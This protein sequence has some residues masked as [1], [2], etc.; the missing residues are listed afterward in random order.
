MVPTDLCVLGLNK[1]A[2]AGNPQKQIRY[3]ILT[4]GSNAILEQLKKMHAFD[5]DDFQYIENEKQKAKDK[6]TSNIPV[7]KNEDVIESN[8]VKGNNKNKMGKNEKMD[9]DNDIQI[10]VPKGKNSNTNNNMNNNTGN[11]N[12]NIS[13]TGNSSNT[14]GK[15]GNSNSQKS[16]F[17]ILTEKIIEMENMLKDPSNVNQKAMLTKDYRKLL[18][19]RGKLV[20]KD[21]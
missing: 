4:G 2:I 8:N 15:K 20:P 6:L 12:S 9:L 17:D 3:N 13:N 10:H 21:N 16:E 1:I 18:I 19:E 14:G 5:D 11:T 7:K